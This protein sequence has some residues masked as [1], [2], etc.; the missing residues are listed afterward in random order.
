MPILLMIGTAKGLFLARSDDHEKWQVSSPHFPECSIYAVGIHPRGEG[1]R[2]LADITSS[3]FGPSV[4]TSDDLGASWHEPEHAPISFP[5][6][7]DAA[8]RQVWQFASS[9]DTV[10]AG[11]QPSA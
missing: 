7:S 2:L 11:T 6:G 3:H 10:F 8:L 5:P 1:L 9:G 4:A